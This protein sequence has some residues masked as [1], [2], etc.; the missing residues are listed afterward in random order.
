MKRGLRFS[1]KYRP[2]SVLAIAGAM[3]DIVLGT[4]FIW[5]LNDI[6]RTL[7]Y[8]NYNSLIP[9]YSGYIVGVM[10]ILSGLSVIYGAYKGNRKRMV[11]ALHVQSL[12]WLFSTLMYALNGS[13]ILAL[14]YGLGFSFLPG[15]IGLHVKFYAPAD[16]REAL[17]KPLDEE[18][19][20]TDDDLIE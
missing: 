14:I 3:R 2:L 13:F 5:G 18:L 20:S 17:S 7:L 4:G 6:T 8:Q 19:D 1:I 12:I 16:E 9:G 15:F 11:R 10:L